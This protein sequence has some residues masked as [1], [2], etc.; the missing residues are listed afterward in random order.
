MIQAML[1]SK[2]SKRLKEFEE[3]HKMAEN[4]KIDILNDFTEE[5]V[6]VFSPT[7]AMDNEDI[8][9]ANRVAAM[10][11]AGLSIKDILTANN[12]ST[13]RMYEILNRKQVPLRKGRKVNTE[14]ARRILMM[15]AK[16][17]QDV[18]IDYRD[19]VKVKDIFKKYDINK[20]GLYSI[21]DEHNVPRKDNPELHTGHHHNNSNRLTKSE[22]EDMLKEFQEEQEATFRSMEED[23]IFAPLDTL[24][25]AKENKLDEEIYAT[26][27]EGKAVGPVTFRKEGDTLFIDVEL[28]ENHPLDKVYVNVS[29]ANSEEEK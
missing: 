20:H 9:E 6:A 27:T 2:Y 16:Q 24:V 7:P 21:L 14:S 1:D 19:G 3:E 13:G 8:S 17:K 26:M 18:I 25:R 23:D 4:K 11:K 22:K 29:L 10:Y 5:E 12:I 28:F 15:T